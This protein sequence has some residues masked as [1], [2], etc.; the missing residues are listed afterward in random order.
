MA[1][2]QASPAHPRCLWRVRNGWV[3]AEDSESVRELLRSLAQRETGEQTVHGRTGNQ[4]TLLASLDGELVR[5]H[6]AA[7]GEVAAKLVRRP[8]QARQS[9]F[10]ARGVLETHRRGE[11]YTLTATGNPIQLEA[12]PLRR[13]VFVGRPGEDGPALLRAMGLTEEAVEELLRAGVIA[14]G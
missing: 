12:A 5:S 11:G 9:E 14:I 10:E 4:E 3:V 2:Q 1:G 13:N 7:A 8:W 6:L